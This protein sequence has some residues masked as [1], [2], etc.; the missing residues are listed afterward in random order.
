MTAIVHDSTDARPIV[1]LEDIHKRYGDV[2]ALRGVTL[3]V[4]RGEHVAIIGSSGSGKSTLLRCVNQLEVI[5]SG[6]ITINGEVL[7]D[8]EN[9]RV[10]YLPERSIRRILLQTAMVFQHFN[11]FG[12]L[13]CLDNITIAPI[14]IKKE[15]PGEVRDRAFGLLKM[16]GLEQKAKAYPAQLS[17]GQKPRIAL[18]RALAMR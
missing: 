12:H 1:E 17:A 5:D 3:R 14:E 16:V 11:L 4:A 10:R 7:A 15:D 18:A 6:R 9:G 2:H 8:T 13:T